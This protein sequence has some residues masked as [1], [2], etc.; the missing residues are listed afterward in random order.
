[1]KQTLTAAVAVVAF[2]VFRACSETSEPQTATDRIYAKERAARQSYTSSEV[3]SLCSEDSGQCY[4]MTV[5]IHHVFLDDGRE[6]KT[7]AGP[8]EFSNGGRLD[9]AGTPIPGAAED[10][11]GKVWTISR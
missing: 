1:M 3:I 8:I 6:E 5:A 11:R 9:V 10:Q 2:A 4:P 7:L